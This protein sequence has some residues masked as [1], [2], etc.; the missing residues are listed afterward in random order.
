MILRIV[1]LPAPLGPT[2]PILAPGITAVVTSSRITLSPTV[3]RART[4]EKMYSAMPSVYGDDLAHEAPAAA[5]RGRAHG[6]R[7]AVAHLAD[8]AAVGGQH[9]DLE[10]R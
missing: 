7:L 1:D 10:E 5:E 9:G 4:I 2:T 8:D 6:D 3:L